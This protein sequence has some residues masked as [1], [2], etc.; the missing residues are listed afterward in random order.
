M[1]LSL[2]HDQMPT[3]MAG[4][5][6]LP[7]ELLLD[8][9]DH[10]SIRNRYDI[11]LKSWAGA[12]EIESQV[13]RLHSLS[14]VSRK[15]H[16]I[17]NPLLY[18][19]LTCG[20]VAR[21]R[22]QFLR[23]VIR[24]P[25]LGALVEEVRF[26]YFDWE[27]SDKGIPPDDAD[28][29]EAAKLVDF[30]NEAANASFQNVPVGEHSDT[31]VALLFSQLPRLKTVE[32]EADETWFFTWKW[33]LCLVRRAVETGS[34]PLSSLRHLKAR[35]GNENKSGF[36]PLFIQDWAALP[37][38]KSI[39]VFGAWSDERAGDRTVALPTNNNIETLVIWRSFLDSEFLACALE[40]F[41]KLKTLHFSRTSLPR[42]LSPRRRRALHTAL[43]AQQGTLEHIT[44]VAGNEK[45]IWS[46]EEMCLFLPPFHSF[47]EF[48]RL[49]RLEIPEFFL[50]DL[51]EYDEDT[52]PR[53]AM[54]YS[55]MIDVFPPSLEALRLEC[56]L[57]WGG[58]LA[59]DHR[60][61]FFEVLLENAPMKMPNLRRIEILRHANNT[62]EQDFDS[63]RTL[64]SRSGRGFEI[65][66]WNRWQHEGLAT[67][68]VC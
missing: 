7:D 46:D 56:Y 50:M 15:L 34:G 65:T 68:G 2:N 43:A 11:D 58:P 24:R 39:E 66:E 41:G 4:L 63:L 36:N 3:K 62:E 42:H 40:A 25:D 31:D 37:A 45:S 19:V 14:L 38:L 51:A 1:S 29:R 20:G 57:S 12:R 54:N 23:T 26:S 61:S 49:K 28:L 18:S 30:G 16:R 13:S 17:V 59:S 60:L 9:V 47:K 53:R 35:Y 52:Q 33:L 64:V 10:F 67:A 21:A 22:R 55:A 6:D 27:S 8:I 5:E 44:I 32:F 48:T